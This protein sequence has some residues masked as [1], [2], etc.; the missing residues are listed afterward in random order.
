[1]PDSVL[2]D[3][4]KQF[5]LNRPIGEV[6]AQLVPLARAD[7]AGDKVRSKLGCWAAACFFFAVV[8][9][10]LSAAVSPYFL[11][12]AVAMI[13]L[14]IVNLTKYNRKK[15]EDL[16]DNLRL[17]AIPLLAALRDDFGSEPVEITLDLRPPLSNEKKT[18]EVKNGSG[19]RKE[20]VTT[21]VD[22]WLSLDGILADGSRLQCSVVETITQRARW[23]R[24]ASGKYKQKTKRKKKV[25]VEVSLTLKAKRFD[26]G[27]ITNAEVKH[28]EN[29]STVSVSQKIARADDTPIPPAEVLNVI[30]GVYRQLR[31][32]RSS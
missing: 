23:K 14:G 7:E 4:Q 24:S 16:S 1:M 9:F 28:G 29:K 30:A 27:G 25:D 2:A 19:M 5:S 15:K 31:P 10:I 6:I 12:L 32:A 18:N 11:A 22:P 17:C 21:Y 13:V 3:Q 26:V 20:T 8:S